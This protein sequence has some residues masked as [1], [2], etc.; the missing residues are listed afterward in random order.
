MPAVS[1]VRVTVSSNISVPSIDPAGSTNSA[2]PVPSVVIVTAVVD[3]EPKVS[4]AAPPGYMERAAT[5]LS[6]FAVMDTVP[7]SF[8]PNVKSASVDESSVSAFCKVRVEDKVRPG[9][10]FAPAKVCVPVVTNPRFVADASGKLNVCVVPEDAI[11]KSVPVVEV[12]KVCVAPVKVFKVVM[13]LPVA[14]AAHSQT[15]VVLFHFNI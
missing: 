12:A 7:A 2:V 5:A 1:V 11:L 4:P 9:N 14:S 13:P 10:V 15:E 3:A 8:L 6:S